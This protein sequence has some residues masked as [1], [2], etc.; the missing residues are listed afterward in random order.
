M[1]PTFILLVITISGI[2]TAHTHTLDIDE[3]NANLIPLGAK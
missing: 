1:K 2:L 3:K